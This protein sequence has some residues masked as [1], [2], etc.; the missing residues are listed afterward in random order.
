MTS[1]QWNIK[2]QNKLR[3]THAK[4]WAQLNKPHVAQILKL[5]PPSI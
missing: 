1:F 5:T 2:E 3:D 4:P